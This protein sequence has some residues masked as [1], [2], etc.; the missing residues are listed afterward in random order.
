MDIC[1]GF[2][3]RHIQDYIQVK[4]KSI[5]E[6]YC[7]YWCMQINQTFAGKSKQELTNNFQW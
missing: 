3:S 4:V 1:D 7:L 2:I 6:K 5:S